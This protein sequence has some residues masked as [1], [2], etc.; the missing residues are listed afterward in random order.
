M[1][2]SNPTFFD[3]FENWHNESF[4]QKKKRRIF[5]SGKSFPQKNLR[6]SRTQAQVFAIKTR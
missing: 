2:F 1:S 6:N 4:K 3:F 5:Y